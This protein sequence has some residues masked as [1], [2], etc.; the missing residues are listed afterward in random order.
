MT[1]ILDGINRRIDNEKENIT[2]LK[3]VLSKMKQRNKKTK[4]MNGELVIY[5]LTSHYLIHIQQE[6]QKKKGWDSKNV[7]I[8]HATNLPNLMNTVNPQILG[9]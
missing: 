1:Y 6:S 7:L 3:F 2:E 9:A 8:S 4:I 5:C